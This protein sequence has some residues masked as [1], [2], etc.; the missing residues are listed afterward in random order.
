MLRKWGQ[1]G[2]GLKKGREEGRKFCESFNLTPHTF[3]FPEPQPHWSVSG[4]GLL[5]FPISKWEKV[6]K[7]LV[8]GLFLGQLGKERFRLA[9]ETITWEGPW[10]YLFLWANLTKERDL[11]NKV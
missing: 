4:I 10:L 1:G 3:L 11:I 5:Y 2:R 6:G 8:F 9:S 7:L